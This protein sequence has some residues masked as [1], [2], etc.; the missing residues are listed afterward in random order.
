MKTFRMIG[1]ALVAVLM[2]VNFTACGGSD[3]E[4]ENTKESTIELLMGTWFSG[5]NSEDYPFFIVEKGFCYFSPDHKISTHGEKYKYTFDSRTIILTCYQYDYDGGYYFDFADYFRVK[6]ITK[7]K[8]TL[9]FLSDDMT[10]K[11]SKSFVRY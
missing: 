11:R 5:D 6:S 7:D 2:C 1:M 3:D 4:D 9:E 10:V 8:V